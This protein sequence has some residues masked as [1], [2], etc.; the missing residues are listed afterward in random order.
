[1]GHNLCLDIFGAPSAQEH[2]A[3]IWVH[4][5]GSVVPYE[6]ESS[7]TRLTATAH[8]PLAMLNFERRV[9]LASGGFLQ[10]HE[11]VTNL[12]AMDRPI[13]WTQHVT[14]GPPFLQPGIT[15]LVVPARRSKVYPTALGPNQHYV[16]S[17]EFEWPHAPNTG[18]GITD[19]DTFPDFER[20]TGVTAHAVDD[21]RDQAYFLTWEP[22]SR[23]AF[24][25]VW[26]RA[27]FPWISLWEEN[28]ARANPPWNGQTI[29]RG[30]EFGASPFAEGR[31]ATIERG[32]LFGVPTYRW[33]PARAS[34]TVDYMAF[35]FQSGEMPEQLVSALQGR[36]MVSAGSR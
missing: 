13:A 29:T 32:S 2:E 9:E 34:V 3:G 28:R 21:D 20:S 6:I 31:R 35:A 19:L 4:G 30:V 26:K 10:I 36:G 8:L 5:E 16:A 24:G 17:A 11:T 14:L 12:T 1:M 27:D 23:L 22:A 15:R 33:L 7:G 25:Y 18:G